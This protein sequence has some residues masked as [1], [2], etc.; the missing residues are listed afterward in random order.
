MKYN[1]KYHKIIIKNENRNLNIEHIICIKCYNQIKNDL[2][3]KKLK[4]IKCN[5]CKQEHS[6]DEI[7]VK[8]SECCCFF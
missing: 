3:D 1:S 4:K 6:F 2:K 5:I 7:K 8:S